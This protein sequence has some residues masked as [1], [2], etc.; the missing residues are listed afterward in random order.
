MSDKLDPIFVGSASICF[1]ISILR[2]FYH[3]GYSIDSVFN[4]KTKQSFRNLMFNFKI[5][6]SGVTNFEK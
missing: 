5:G 6:N 3:I 1:A 2:V 4:D